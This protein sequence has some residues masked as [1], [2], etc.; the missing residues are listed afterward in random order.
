MSTIQMEELQLEKVKLHIEDEGGVPCLK[1]DG[2]IDMEDPGEEVS[3]Y[4]E[5]LH[6][7]ILEAGLK[8]VHVDFT[9]LGFMNSSGLKCFVSWIMQLN[10]VDEDE[11]YKIIIKYLED[12]TWQS[13]SLPVLHDLSPDLIEIKTV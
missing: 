1:I 13:S 8:E 4:L 10:D 3:P 2:E 6:E 7:T 9:S 5:K 11:E 12:V